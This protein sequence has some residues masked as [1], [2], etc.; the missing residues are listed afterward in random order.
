MM[1]KTF[2]EKTKNQWNEIREIEGWQIAKVCW[3]DLPWKIIE[4]AENLEGK[5]KDDVFDKVAKRDYPWKKTFETR[6]EL[7]DYIKEV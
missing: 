6:K 4:P 5:N 3:H 1:R 2:V 7:W